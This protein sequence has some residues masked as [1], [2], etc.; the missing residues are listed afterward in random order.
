MP[1]AVDPNISQ[2]IVVVTF[3]PPVDVEQDHRD[4]LDESVRRLGE[5]QSPL[6]RVLDFRSAYMNFSDMIRWLAADTTHDLPGAALDP[7]V[8]TVLVSNSEDTDRIANWLE[9]DQYG[10]LHIPLFTSIDD[11]LTYVTQQIA[12]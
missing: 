7:Q 11:A 6:Y 2:N 5:G 12:S 1:F 8:R 4:L 9:Q 3:Y 10:G